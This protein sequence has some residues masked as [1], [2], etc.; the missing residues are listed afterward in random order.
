MAQV[1]H[2]DLGKPFFV[3]FDAM[4][5][6]MASHNIVSCH[7]SISDE[8]AYATAMVVLEA[9]YNRLLN[10]IA[11]ST[12]TY[13]D[14]KGVLVAKFFVPKSNK[15]KARKQSTPI[16]LQIDANDHAGN[17]LC[18]SSKPITVVQDALEGEV[19]ELRFS[20]QTKKVNF[21]DVVKVLEPSEF[22][23]T[24][25]CEY[26]QQ[27][28]G[29]SL[30]HVTAKHGLALKEKALQTFVRNK[31][32]L[33]DQYEDATLWQK[34][35]LSD[36]DY[37]EDPVN[38]SYRRRIRLAI[39]ARNKQ[40]VKIGFRS[41]H[42]KTIVDIAK[43][44]IASSAIND[45]L[46]LLRKTIAY[47]PSV[48]K[49]GHIVVTEADNSLQIA[50][51]V[52]Q[53]LCKKSNEKLSIFASLA[54]I[55]IVVNVK[56]G[57]TICLPQTDSDSSDSVIIEDIPSVKLAIKSSHFLQVNK[58]VNQSMIKK[59]KAW[60][61]PDESYTL[62]DFFCGSGNFAL[63][64][65]KLVGSVN[66]YEGLSEMVESA[67]SNAKNMGVKN[68]HF[69]SADLSS[70]EEVEGL[71]FQTKS[72]V[73]LDPSR[74]GAL[75]LCQFLANKGVEKILYVSCNPNSFVRDAKHFLPAYHL[76]KICALDMFPF[77]KHLEVMALFTLGKPVYN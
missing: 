76:S 59:A 16:T 60:L 66:A 75:E 29:C 70:I 14:R 30:Q 12:L 45:C 74:E 53:A 44:A 7:L 2:D 11:N 17:G 65:A 51:F 46:P 27:C 6:F 41:A 54:T 49:I 18:L 15:S 58:T 34:P 10:F 9:K 4:E 50:L 38:T 33:P 68:C 55:S 64:F 5:I 24:P 72:M 62:Y 1:E 40:K 25:F 28:G 32:N 52:S 19:C 31:L 67:K 26:Y 73:I 21:A 22:R 43:C 77:T 23:V 71:S 57:E 48:H 20:K 36:I 8:K 3:F 37:S 63:S 61:A 42:S 56:S 39:D 35:V 47:L 69:E 13:I